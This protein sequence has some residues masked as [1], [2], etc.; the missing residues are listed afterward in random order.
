[1]TLLDMVLRNKIAFVYIL[2]SFEKLK[3]MTPLRAG[4]NEFK[5]TTQEIKS[6]YYYTTFRIL[7]FSRGNRELRT[8]L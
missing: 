8:T 6:K 2:H 1:M 7:T 3:S 5:N 4:F